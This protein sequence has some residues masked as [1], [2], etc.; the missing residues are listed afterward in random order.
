VPEQWDLLGYILSD[1]NVG[2]HA[3][4]VLGA[5]QKFEDSD[6]RLKEFLFRV[7]QLPEQVKAQNFRSPATAK[8][9]LLQSANTARKLAF[10][11]SSDPDLFDVHG[12][13][14]Y[15]KSKINGHVI[16]G[17]GDIDLGALLRAFAT[18]SDA[19]T[20]QSLGVDDYP[21]GRKD[22]DSALENYV[23]EQIS[24][25]AVVY[26][27]KTFPDFTAEIAS[28]VLDADIGEAKV[29]SRTPGLPGMSLE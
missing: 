18:E 4:H 8:Q 24:T 15:L 5:I 3:Q 10:Q 25:L 21:V 14:G 2:A 19:R 7:S 20:L 17:T 23:I 26:L 12:D 13:V 11:L 6:D 9:L 27:G 16:R 1:A 22:G 28:V 29:R